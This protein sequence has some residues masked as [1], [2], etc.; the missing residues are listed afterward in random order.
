MTE[1]V[2]D[3]YAMGRTSAETERLQLQADILARTVRIWCVWLGSRRVLGIGCRVGDTSMLLAELVGP[4]GSVVGVD[5]ASARLDLARTGAVEAGL[6]G[7]SFVESDLAKLRRDEPVDALFG[8]W[9][10]ALGPG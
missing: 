5:V 9:F 7:E 1:S 4:E 10:T 6:T 8:R 2:D 3:R